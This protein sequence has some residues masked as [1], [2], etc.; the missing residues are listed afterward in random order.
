MESLQTLNWE[1]VSPT[2]IAPPVVFQVIS[3]HQTRE[4]RW[5]DQMRAICTAQNN[6]TFYKPETKQDKLAYFAVEDFGSPMHTSTSKTGF[7]ENK[8]QMLKDEM[9]NTIYEKKVSPYNVK[10]SYK[11]RRL[12]DIKK[13]NT[14]AVGR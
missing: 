11:P 10:S 6:V 8:V 12:T 2:N 3:M 14:K 7:G 13:Q 5:Q 1:K 9:K 4:S